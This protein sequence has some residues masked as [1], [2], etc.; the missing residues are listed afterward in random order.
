MPRWAERLSNIQ[1]YELLHYKSY[2]LD[3]MQE[4]LHGSSQSLA[5][6]HI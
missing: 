3:K 5:R 6:P 2:P 4:P 1:T